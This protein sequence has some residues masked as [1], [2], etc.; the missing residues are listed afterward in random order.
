MRWGMQVASR[1]QVKM[2]KKKKLESF[3]KFVCLEGCQGE[4]VCKM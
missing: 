4:G 1:I 2:F 3:A